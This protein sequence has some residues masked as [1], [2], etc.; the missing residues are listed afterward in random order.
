MILK[1]CKQWSSYKRC[2]FK[3]VVIHFPKFTGKHLCWSLP[4]NA[5]AGLQPA[6]LLMKWLW[7]RSGVSGQLYLKKLC[8]H[9]LVDWYSFSSWFWCSYSFLVYFLFPEFE[10]QNRRYTSP[11]YYQNFGSN[12][13]LNRKHRNGGS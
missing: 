7:H 11:F 5:A 2:S 3:K 4:S 9:Y 12:C 1:T 13:K 6:T 8:R 10:F